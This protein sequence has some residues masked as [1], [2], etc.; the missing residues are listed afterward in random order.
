V[1]VQ[2]RATWKSGQCTCRAC[3]Q[4]QLASGGSQQPDNIL[5]GGGRGLGVLV[6][7]TLGT[8]SE[9]LFVLVK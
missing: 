9:E 4:G 5:V 7:E 6:V 1:P 8:G 3:V 2:F